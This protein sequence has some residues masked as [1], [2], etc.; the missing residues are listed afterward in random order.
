MTDTCSIMT[1]CQSSVL[2]NSVMHL[3]KSFPICNRSLII[4]ALSLQGVRVVWVYHITW[5]INSVCHVWGK[6]PWKTGD[7]SRNNGYYNFL[8][9]KIYSI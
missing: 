9:F 7:L 3:Y 6:Q 5:L 4:A 2:F 1:T 8:K